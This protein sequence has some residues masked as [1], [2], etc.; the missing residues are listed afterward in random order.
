MSH[1]TATTQL[2]R[3]PDYADR[4]EKRLLIPWQQPRIRALVRS[5]A[6]GA[7]LHEDQSFDLIASTGI[8]EATGDA[9]D[10]WGEL[11]GEQ[12]GPLSD[13]EFRP[14]VLARML[15]NRCSGTVD[16]LLEIFDIVTEPN[17]GVFHANN[18]PAGFYMVTDR[19]EFMSDEQCRRVARMMEDCRPAGR[20][21][22]LIEALADGFGWQ[23]DPT[24][25]GFGI[26]PFSRLIELA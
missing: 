22:T 12:R 9:L 16:E 6:E 3:I 5:L 14:F 13:N 21:M 18:F 7:Q 17:A 15:I 8:E 26:G 1:E 25:A 20:H 19:L 10:Q 23:D 2:V 11:V 4:A 24:A